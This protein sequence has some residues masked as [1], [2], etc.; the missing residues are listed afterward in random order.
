MNI[1]D[2]IELVKIYIEKS[3]FEKARE[4]LFEVKEFCEKNKEYAKLFVNDPTALSQTVGY[5]MAPQTVICQ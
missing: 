3:L 1:N 2:M 5:L 4:L